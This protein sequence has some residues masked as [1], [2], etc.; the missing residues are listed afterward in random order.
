MQ[1]LKLLALDQDDLEIISAHLQ[2]AVLKVSDVIWRPGE[3]R[4]VVALNRFDWEAAQWEKPEYRRRRT[5]LR[6]DCVKSIKCRHVTPAEKEAVL[7]LLA[8]TFEQTDP[9]AGVVTLMFSGGAAL[10]L[11]VECVEAQIA[12]LGPVWEAAACPCHA[13]EAAETSLQLERTAVA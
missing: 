8:V 11:E 5:A 2:D 3:K 12:D 10:R 9:P 4:L 13:D 7:N 6:F 1:S